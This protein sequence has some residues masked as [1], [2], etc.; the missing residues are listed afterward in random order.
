MGISY[1][2]L[3]LKEQSKRFRILLR[4]PSHSKS[5]SFTSTEFMPPFSF[6]IS[7]VFPASIALNKYDRPSIFNLPSYILT[8]SNITLALCT[9]DDGRHE[10]IHGAA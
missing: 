6:I 9:K 5:F 7:F 2:R 4:K 10:N 1:M 3:R 8:F